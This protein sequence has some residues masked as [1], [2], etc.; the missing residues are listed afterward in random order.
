MGSP[1]CALAVRFEARPR[2]RP[3]PAAT[4]A[5]TEEL[6]LTSDEK[7]ASDSLMSLIAGDVNGGESTIDEPSIDRGVDATDTP[8]ERFADDRPRPRPFGGF[9]DAIRGE[10]RATEDSAMT[11][12]SRLH[13]EESSMF[14]HWEFLALLSLSVLCRL[15]GFCLNRGREHKQALRPSWER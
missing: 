11:K 9:D 13:V 6:L 12:T 10:S 2:P 3:R 1:I 15:I 8:A 4:G 14:P 7:P 5:K